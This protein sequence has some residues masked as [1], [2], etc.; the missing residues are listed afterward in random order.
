[1]STAQRRPTAAARCWRWPPSCS[2]S[3]ACAPR[4]CATSPTPPA[5]CPAACITTSTPR[6]R[7]ST[8]SCASFLD[9]LFG[10]LPRDRRAAS[11][12]RARPSK[13][14]SSPRSRRSTSS[15]DAVAIYQ[16][17]ARR[18]AASRAS[19]TSTS[20]GPSSARCGTTCCDAGVADGSF[21]ADLDVELA[22]RFLRDTVWVGVRLVP[23][24]RALTSTR[25]RSSTCRSS[26]TASPPARRPRASEEPAMAEAY[27]VD[28][29]RTPVG[30]RKGALSQVHPA[31]L[32]AHVITALF[33]AQPERRP[34][35]RRRRHLRLHRHPRPA[36]RRHR[37]HLLAGRRLLRRGARRDRRPA[38]RLEP[39]G[40]A[41]RRPGRAERHRRPRRRRR[42]AEHERD[43][44]RLGDD[45]RPAV[46]L[47][48]AVRRLG[49]LGEALRRPG[50][51]AVPGRRHDRREVGHQPRG[52]GGVRPREP[53]PRA[54]RH[55]RGPVRPTRSCPSARWR[56]TRARAPTRRWRRWPGCKTAARGR[57]DHRRRRRRRSPTPP[58]RC[59]S[60]PRP[61]CARF[62]L[63]PRARVHHLS[64]RG[65]DPVYMLTAPIRATRYALEQGRADPRRHRPGRD[66]RGVR[67][68]RAG[69][70]EGDRRRPRPRSTSTAAPSRSATR[71]APPGRS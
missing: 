20:G 63:T 21:R 60:P 27:I 53:P 48:D 23:P 54:R 19:P 44:D 57:P 16:S 56:P 10:Q 7:W 37:P 69:L 11:S 70:G 39:A 65:D 45:G 67:V 17:E 12:R 64:V 34:G 51:L 32:G 29:V 33:D 15:H 9:E 2:P 55:R 26:W 36:G 28:A 22:Y 61:R 50:G 35:R 46:R 58:A 13:P 41:L 38:V 25:S 5:S 62:G 30:R 8:R 14:S 66:Q 6:S 43:P 31:D 71:S 52:D 24:G 68:G 18:L 59:W 1:M 49:R 4:P 3:A 47:R 40:R 42:R